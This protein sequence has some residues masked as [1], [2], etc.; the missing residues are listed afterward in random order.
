MI[1]GAICDSVINDADFAM[2]LPTLSPWTSGASITHNR[3]L[4]SLGE[5]ASQL[6]FNHRDTRFYTDNNRGPLNAGRHAER[7][8]HVP[9]ARALHQDDGRHNVTLCFLPMRA[10]AAG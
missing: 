6:H 2:E 1:V 7:E 3:H 10:S 5:L 8:P 9:P 4:G